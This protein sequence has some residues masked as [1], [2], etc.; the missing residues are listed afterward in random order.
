V[1]VNIIIIIIIIIQF[2]VRTKIITEPQFIAEA[3]ADHFP[4]VFNTQINMVFL[5][6]NPP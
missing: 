4:S 3:Y 5:N 2:E 1:H 6:Q